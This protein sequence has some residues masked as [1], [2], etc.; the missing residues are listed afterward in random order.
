MLAY[1]CYDLD[2]QLLDLWYN[3]LH[4]SGKEI[5]TFLFIQIPL[6]LT[7][8]RRRTTEFFKLITT[9]LYYTNR[10]GSLIITMFSI[11]R[12]NSIYPKVLKKKKVLP[13][14]SDECIW[15]FKTLCNWEIWE[16]SETKKKKQLCYFWTFCQGER[17]SLWGMLRYFRTGFLGWNG[18]DAFIF[19]RFLHGFDWL[20][21]WDCQLIVG[22][23]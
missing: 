4:K 9:T 7:H 12:S 19:L 13:P 17:Y 2:R 20:L 22:A 11:T 15:N 5:S 21:L 3:F 23:E 6:K 16:E 14:T 1:S 8:G 18:V 10:S